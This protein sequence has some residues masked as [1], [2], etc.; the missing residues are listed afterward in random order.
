MIAARVETLGAKMLDGKAPAK[1]EPERPKWAKGGGIL[2]AIGLALWKL[3]LVIVLVL[4][5]AKLLILGLTKI[6]TLLSMMLAFGVYWTLWGWP[7]A[8]GF[9]ISIYIHEMG[10]VLWLARYGIKATAPMFIPGIGALVR[11]KQ[12]PPVPGLDAR[13]GLAGP[14]YGLGAAVASWLLFLATGSAV[15]G[16]IARVGAWVNLFN[17]MPIWSLDGGRG[18]RA[19]T[20]QERLITAGVIGLAWYVSSE[21]LLLL[22]LILALYRAF[23]PA[24]GKPDRTVL[25]MYTGL[26]I[27]LSAIA[28]IHIPGAA[29]GR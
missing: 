5:K 20:K 3:K 13:V 25:L 22:L 9:I 2:G 21:P 11:L 24:P 4:T 15:F 8:A 29:T 28:S 19:L 7:F 26:I 27:A 18:F 16:G 14:L 12:Y 10:H 1:P 23:T 6:S 17:L